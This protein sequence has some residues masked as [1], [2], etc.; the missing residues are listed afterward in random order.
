VDGAGGIGLG[1]VD[2][3]C[4]PFHGRAWAL[5]PRG[6]SDVDLAVAAAKK[7]FYGDAWAS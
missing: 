6:D 1:R 4:E 2:R 3:V 7:A 5:I